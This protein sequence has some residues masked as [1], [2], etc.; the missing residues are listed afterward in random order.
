MPAASCIEH[1]PM[2][3]FRSVQLRIEPVLFYAH[4]AQEHRPSDRL[5]RCLTRQTRCTICIAYIRLDTCGSDS[6]AANRVRF[7]RLK[8][9][10][11]RAAPLNS[12]SYGPILHKVLYAIYLMC[13]MTTACCVFEVIQ[14]PCLPRHTKPAC[15]AVHHNS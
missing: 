13:Y 1:L 14:H 12:S 10:H 15:T 6:R 7:V 3:L 4:L 5:A 8:P 11:R 9:H 2:L